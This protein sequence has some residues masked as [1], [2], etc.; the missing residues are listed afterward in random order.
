MVLLLQDK[1]LFNCWEN[2]IEKISSQASQEE[3]STTIPKGST[4]KWAEMGGLLIGV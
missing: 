1:N 4:P 2:S 3:G